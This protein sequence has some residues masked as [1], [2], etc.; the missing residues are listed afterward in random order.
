MRTS[1]EV[2]PG[3]VIEMRDGKPIKNKLRNRRWSAEKQGRFFDHLAASCNVVASAE[4]AEV[5]TS[6]A[7]RMKR[8][9]PEFAALWHRA[10]ETGYSTLETMLVGR[11][12]KA[13]EVPVG[14]TDVPDPNLMSTETALRVLDRHRREVTGQV[15][16]GGPIPRRATEEEAR[17]AILAKLEILR[18]RIDAG[19]A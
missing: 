11:A 14:V 10:L 12:L 2:E 9:D 16:T 13:V 8:R 19:E 5:C 4:A 7:Y 17:D 15:K 6:T 3:I 18:A 1:V